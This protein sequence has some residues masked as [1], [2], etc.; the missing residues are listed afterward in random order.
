MAWTY[1][2]APRSQIEEFDNDSNLDGDTR[3]SYYQDLDSDGEG[4]ADVSVQ[5]CSQ[6]DGFVENMTDCDD[7][8]AEDLDGDGI[9][10]CNHLV[11]CEVFSQ[12]SN[13]SRV[14]REKAPAV[15]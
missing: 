9:Q 13:F 10:N 3:V 4:N 12:P 14:E 2:S 5:F 8:S 11:Y 15:Q 1:I 7:T 6:P